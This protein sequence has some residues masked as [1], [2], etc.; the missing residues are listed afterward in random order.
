MAWEEW[1]SESSG[2]KEMTLSQFEVDFQTKLHD[3]VA[4]LIEQGHYGAIKKI[5]VS[6]DL[7]FHLNGP[8]Y[9]HIDSKIE[10]EKEKE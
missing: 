5:V 10:I 2:E 6:K 1:R 4:F 3:L 7:W 8:D 9:Y